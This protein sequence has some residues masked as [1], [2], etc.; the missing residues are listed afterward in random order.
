MTDTG[1]PGGRHTR[2]LTWGFYAGRSEQ[3]AI[4]IIEAWLQ[5]HGPAAPS[6][7]APAVTVS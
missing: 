1:D 2:R 7:L 6:S 3:E 4:D 5:A